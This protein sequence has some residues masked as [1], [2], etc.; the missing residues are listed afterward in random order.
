MAG[1]LADDFIHADAPFEID[2]KTAIKS[3]IDLIEE[4]GPETIAALIA[5]P[6]QGAG[7]VIIPPEGYI[8]ELKKTCEKYNILFIA[9]EVI[10]GFG[11]TGKMFGVE[12]WNIEP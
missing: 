3:V 10:T 11:R 4:E 6:M 5:E 9:D 1:L 12:N 7:G 8:E 2:T